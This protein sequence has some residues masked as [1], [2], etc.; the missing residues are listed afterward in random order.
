MKE[1][2]EK[3]VSVLKSE[4]SVTQE[5]LHGLQF[6]LSELQR[7]KDAAYAGLSQEHELEREQ[8]ETSLDQVSSSGCTVS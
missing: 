1:Q 2:L 7:E 6:L 3:E 8:V 4:L 5:Q